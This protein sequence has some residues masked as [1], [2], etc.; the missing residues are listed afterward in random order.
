M[1]LEKDA[2]KELERTEAIIRN[3]QIVDKKADSLV[4]VLDAYYED[5]KIF[6]KKRQYLQSLEA[7]FIVWA[8]VDA[9]LHLNVFKVPDDM[10]KMFTV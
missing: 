8:Y 6:F 3:L 7:S 5:S 4:K 10:K 9:G 2:E 1:Q